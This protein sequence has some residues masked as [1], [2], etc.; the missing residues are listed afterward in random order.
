MSSAAA[1][2]ACPCFSLNCRCSPAAHAS[3]AFWL[4]SQTNPFLLPTY[5]DATLH[6]VINPL[7]SFSA[8][9]DPFSRPFLFPLFLFCKAGLPPPCP[10]TCEEHLSTSTLSHNGARPF[11]FVLKLSSSAGP[12][13]FCSCPSYLVFEPLTAATVVSTPPATCPITPRSYR[14]LP[15]INSTFPRPTSALPPVERIPP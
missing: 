6:I 9:L 3:S 1:S 7:R 10:T 14:C 15:P 13:R 11:L 4:E 12:I 2:Q 5:T 8:G